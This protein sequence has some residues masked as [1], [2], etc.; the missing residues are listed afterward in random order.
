M[1]SRRTRSRSLT[2]VTRPLALVAGLALALAVAGCG[3]SASSTAT[4][5]TS[6]S[7][8]ASPGASLGLDSVKISGAVETAPVVAWSG[9]LTD[10][11]TQTKTVVQGK[12]AKV[13]KGDAVVIQTW[14]G[15]GTTEKTAIDSHTKNQSE[16]VTVDDTITP[17]YLQLAGKRIGSR[18]AISE[19]AAS[20]FGSSG[21]AQLGIGANDVVV[22]MFDLVR[23]VP[24]RSGPDGASLGA[25][26]WAPSVKVTSGQPSA[27]GFTGVPKPDGTLRSATL[28]KGTGAKVKKGQSVV[29]HYLGQ[30]YRGAK[31]FDENFSA[32][33]PATFG[34]GVGAVVKGWDK[35]LV[36]QRVGS[37]TIMA[38]PPKDGYGAKGQPSAGIKGTDTLYFVVDILAAA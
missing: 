18:V 26:G 25:P 5:S 19:P 4:S 27:L 31:P 16:L 7:G 13:G 23:R 3:S 35:T 15:D 1:L 30:V 36:G 24:V 32:G 37:R 9:P 21:N 28:R 17:L 8:G 14:I 2:Q 29:V 33:A 11:S 20:V 34:I 12:G 22:V 38:V 6:P 10:T